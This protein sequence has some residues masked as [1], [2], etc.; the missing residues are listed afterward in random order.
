MPQRLKL[1]IPLPLGGLAAFP[2]GPLPPYQATVSAETAEAF[3]RLTS[4][5]PGRRGCREAGPS[6]LGR[7]GSRWPRPNKLAEAEEVVAAYTTQASELPASGA[8]D[9]SGR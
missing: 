3:G 9:V 1:L 7:G 2:Q 5:Q 8:S 4:S 6:A